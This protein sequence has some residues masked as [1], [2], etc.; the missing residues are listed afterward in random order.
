VVILRPSSRICLLVPI[1]DRIVLWHLA[2]LSVCIEL[3]FG[4][5]ERI[6]K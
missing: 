4:R 1:Y 6:F 5:T 3:V 2:L